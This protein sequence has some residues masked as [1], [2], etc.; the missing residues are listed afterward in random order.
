M[1]LIFACISSNATI[2]I[3]QMCFLFTVW[4]KCEEE[5]AWLDQSDIVQDFIK[6]KKMIKEQRTANFVT[7]GKVTFKII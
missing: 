2:P 4:N 3:E 5:I 7:L 1:S 6:H